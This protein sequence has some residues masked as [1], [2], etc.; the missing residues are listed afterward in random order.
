MFYFSQQLEQEDSSDATDRPSFT[1]DD[2]APTS[3]KLNPDQKPGQT[4]EPEPTYISSKSRSMYKNMFVQGD[5]E[6]TGKSDSDKSVNKKE[7]E[8]EWPEGIRICFY[9][10]ATVNYLML[11][12]CELNSQP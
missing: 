3:F 1:M 11:I 12:E 7:T 5:S 10:K 4:K 9:H 2:E 6:F 8:I